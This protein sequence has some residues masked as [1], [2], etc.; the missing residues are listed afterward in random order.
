MLHNKLWT[1]FG[2]TIHTDNNP[3]PRFLRNFLMQGNGAEMLRLACCMLIESGIKVCAPIHDAVLIES[4]LDSLDNDIKKA[5]QLME[6][7]SAAILNGFTLRSDVEVVRSPNRY[8]D[9]RGKNMW[10]KVSEIL[11]MNKSY[12]EFNNA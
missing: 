4:S 2:W 3:N 10:E 8:L 7:A 9:E 12:T 11:E 1:V 6:E 5:Q